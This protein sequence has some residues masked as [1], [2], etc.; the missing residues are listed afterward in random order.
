MSVRVVAPLDES[1][2]VACTEVLDAL[3]A[4]KP[5]LT[6]SQLFGLVFSSVDASPGAV[7]S[8]R[9]ACSDAIAR[10]AGTAVQT[11]G[12]VSFALDAAAIQSRLA[13]LEEVEAAAVRAQLDERAAVN[14]TES[15]VDSVLGQQNPLTD[16]VYVVACEEGGEEGADADAGEGDEGEMEAAV[17]VDTDAAEGDEGEEEAGTDAVAAV[18]DT[19]TDAGAVVEEDVGAPTTDANVAEDAEVGAAVVGAVE[20]MDKVQVARE[21]TD[22]DISS[23]SATSVLELRAD[24]QALTAALV[25]SHEKTQSRIDSFAAAL[26]TSTTGKRETDRDSVAA[27]LFWNEFY[28]GVH[29]TSASARKRANAQLNLGAVIEEARLRALGDAH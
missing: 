16:G 15:V 23:A 26:L 3:L 27:T 2:N 24:I 4:K 7:D 28:H 14:A 29:Q 20:D 22:T 11:S 10:R 6:E 19:A 17:A 8:V 5:D 12:R 1:A 21:E 25:A 13:A 9:L 18:A